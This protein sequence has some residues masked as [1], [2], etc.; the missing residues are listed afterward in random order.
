MKLK[1]DHVWLSPSG[2]AEC[3]SVAGGVKCACLFESVSSRV[4]LDVFICTQLFGHLYMSVC[5]SACVCVCVCV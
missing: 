3:V 5:V 2:S 4:H 1:H